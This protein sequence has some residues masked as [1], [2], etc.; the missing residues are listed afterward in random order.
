MN[1]EARAKSLRLG[2]AL[3]QLEALKSA[4]VE[5]KEKEEEKTSGEKKAAKKSR[6]K[7]SDSSEK[8]VEKDKSE[9][10]EVLC[11]ARVSLFVCSDS[12][13]VR[14]LKRMPRMLKLSTQRWIC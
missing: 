12:T 4:K 5:E 14:S 6:S 11:M 10:T 9:V 1:G 2:D 7:K 8:E 3:A 13:L